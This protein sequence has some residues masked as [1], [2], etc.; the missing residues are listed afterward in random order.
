MTRAYVASALLILNL[1]AIG[2]L[3][4]VVTFAL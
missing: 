3:A 1:V 2:A 4:C